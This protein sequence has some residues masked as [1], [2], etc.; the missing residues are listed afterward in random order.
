MYLPEKGVLNNSNFYFHTPSN[1]AKSSYFYM[2]CAGE[3]FCD[4]DYKVERETFHSYL[5]MYVKKGSGVVSMNNKTYPVQANDLV[6][7]NCHKPHHY[8]TSTGWET[9]WL[10]FDG[11]ASKNFFELLNNRFGYVLAMGGSPIVSRHLTMIVEGFKL[12]KPLPEVL[13]SSYIHRM[14]TELML[15]SSNLTDY[16]GDTNSPVI[17]AMTYIHLNYKGK[18]TVEELATYVNVSVFHFSRV[19]KK[20]TGYSPYEYIIKTRIDHAKALLKQTKLTIKEISYEIGF[21]SESNFV[22]TFRQSVSL[23]PNEFRHTPM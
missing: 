22:N 18:I 11:N 23:T 8:Y 17:D 10:H 6:L 19:F 5:L 13:V 3:F 21:N 14:L 15:I 16:S 20:E 7:L 4:G 2:T 12:D 1:T 9:L